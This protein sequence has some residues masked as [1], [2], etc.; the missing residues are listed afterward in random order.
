M[1][2]SSTQLA[3][4][5]QE[6]ASRYLRGEYQADIARDL[7]I[8][9]QTVSLDLKAIRAAWLASSIRDYDAAIAQELARIDEVEREYWSAW[10]KSKQDK[11]I[12]YQEAGG[13][14]HKKKVSLRRE[15]QAGMPAFL[16]GVLKCIERR[17]RLLGLDAL[18]RFIIDWDSLTPEQMN[19]LAAGEPPQK[20]LTA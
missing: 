8:S 19:R 3:Q 14:G 12:T 20:V 2:R 17:C 7:G 6:I 13:D 1:E 4:H 18:D 5:R 16:D 15:G 11:E 9:Q 10:E